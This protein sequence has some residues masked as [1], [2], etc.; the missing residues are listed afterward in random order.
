ML[1]DIEGIEVVG[2][3]EDCLKALEGIDSSKPDVVILDI[4]MAGG[5]GIDV[6][7]RVKNNTPA[8]VVIMFTNYPYPQYRKNCMGAGADYFFDK[9]TEFH[10]V[11]GILKKLTQNSHVQQY[12]KES[13][14]DLSLLER[15]KRPRQY[16][17]SVTT[18]YDCSVIKI[19]ISIS[20]K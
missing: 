7:K 11:A 4:R 16:E 20:A 2:H 8:P 6:L 3:A 5:N 1:A 9:S 13:P 14:Y 12:L 17:T 18:V 15:G 19:P 10:K